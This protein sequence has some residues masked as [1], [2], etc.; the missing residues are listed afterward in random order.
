GP[1]VPA[2]AGEFRLDLRV[3]VLEPADAAEDFG[4]V[5]GFNRNARLLHQLFAEAHGVERGGSRAENADACVLEPSYNPAGG[6]KGFEIGAE[7]I[8]PRRDGVLGGE[9]KLGA[10]L[11]EVVADRY[12]AAEAVSPPAHEHFPRLVRMSVNE[13][14]HLEPGHAQSVRDAFFIA[15]IRQADN[16][17][18][19]LFAV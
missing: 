16:N 8:R 13:H 9:R 7:G 1:H 18:V 11:P 5:E 10:V 14:G 3:F 17:A 6:R 15:E 19:N 4:E 2:D 12:L